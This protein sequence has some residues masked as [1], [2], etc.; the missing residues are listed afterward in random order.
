MF[1]SSSQRPGANDSNRIPLF[2]GGIFRFSNLNSKKGEKEKDWIL[3]L[4]DVSLLE[5]LS[6]GSL[7]Q[8]SKE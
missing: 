8:S 2:I 6:C 1:F 4:K 5:L 3:T 7:A